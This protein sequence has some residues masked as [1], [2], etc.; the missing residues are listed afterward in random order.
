M[1]TADGEFRFGGVPPGAYRITVT[2]LA[3]VWHV[4]SGLINGVESLDFPVEIRAGQETAAAKVVISNDPTL[5]SGRLVDAD[6]QPVIDLSVVAFPAAEEYWPGAER[7]IQV[8]RPDTEGRFE[9][10][11]LPPGDYFLCAVAGASDARLDDPGYLRLLAQQAL[12]FTLGTN[13]KLTQTFRIAGGLDPVSTMSPRPRSTGGEIGGL[14][15]TEETA[16][17]RCRTTG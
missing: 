11:A 6:G 17:T 5:L 3:D 7:R 13:Q 15:G 9:L 1:S 16:A 8:A 12:R 10:L 4:A 14:P 2:G